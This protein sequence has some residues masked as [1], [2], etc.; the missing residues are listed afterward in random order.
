MRTN[1]ELYEQDFYAW[2]QVQAALLRKGAV[3]ALDLSNLAE[4]V[5]DLGVSQYTA[6]SS[7]LYQVLLHLLQ[8][9]YPPTLRQESHSWRDSIVEQRDRIDRICTRMPSLPPQL[10]AMLADEYPRARRRARYQ[11]GLPLETFPL[12]CPWT[13]DQVLNPD[14]WPGESQESHPTD[15]R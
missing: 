3:D 12:T 7:D 6:V 2:T 9:Q 5:H 11:T 10:P 15:M 13:L 4:E 8:W 14:F 1:A